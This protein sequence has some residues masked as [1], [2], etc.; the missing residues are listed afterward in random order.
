MNG[1]LREE[2]SR[3]L[4]GS[5]ALRACW[6][7]EGEPRRLVSMQ[8]EAGAA[9]TGVAKAKARVVRAEK[10]ILLAKG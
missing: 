2:S 8:C 7:V 9:V 6:T 10:Y 3:G 5:L 4:T 1:S